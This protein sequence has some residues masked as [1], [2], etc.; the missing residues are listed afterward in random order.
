MTENSRELKTQNLSSVFYKLDIEAGGLREDIQIL[1]GDHE[2][3]PGLFF[4]LIYMLIVHT[5]TT[6]S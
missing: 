4:M 3:G 2:K 6:H 5:S 1:N